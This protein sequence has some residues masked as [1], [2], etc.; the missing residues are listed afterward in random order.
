MER[1][2]SWA[3]LWE[4]LAS[5]S[6]TTGA[7]AW[8]LIAPLGAAW[9]AWLAW[10]CRWRPGLVALRFVAWFAVV[11]GLARVALEFALPQRPLAVVAAVDHSASIGTAGRQWQEQYVAELE[12]RLGP[13]DSLSVVAFAGRSEV[14]AWPGRPGPIHWDATELDEGSTDIAQALRR[15]ADLFPLEHERRLVLLSD[16]N[17][18]RSQALSEAPLL[19]ALG[20]QVFSAVPPLPEASGGRVRKVFAAPWL[21]AHSPASLHIGMDYRGRGESHQL[22]QLWFNGSLVQEQSLTLQ[23]GP[24][25]ISFDWQAPVAGAYHWRVRLR[26]ASGATGGHEAETEVAVGGPL[27]VLVVAPRPRSLLAQLWRERGWEVL[28]RSPER[29]RGERS[30]WDALH[31]VALE[32]VASADLPMAFWSALRRFAEE[33]GGVLVVG[34]HRTYNDTALSRTP[35]AEVLPVSPHPSPPPRR[36]RAPL[37]LVLVLDRSNSMA[38][39]VHRRLER[40]ESE[41]KLAYAKRAALNLIDQLRDTDWVGFVA[42]D[43][44]MYEVAPLRP[45]AENRA[46]LEANIPR[47]APGG[48]TDFYEALAHACRVLVAARA[49]VPHIILLTD[50]DTNRAAAEHDALIAELERAGVR[51]TTIRI[52]DDTVNLELLQAISARTGGNFYHVQDAT[53]LPELLLHDTAQTIQQA[54]RGSARYAVRVASPSSLLRNIPLEQLPDLGGYA[55]ARLKPEARLVL[56]VGS[57]E[58]S[59]PLL[60]VWNY[61]LGRVAAFTASLSNGA[62]TWASW[63]DLGKFF[64]QL[65][66]W[67]ARE[68]APADLWVRTGRDGPQVRLELLTDPTAEWGEARGRLSWGDQVADVLFARE[69][70]GRLVALL[71][72][73][74][75]GL[76][77]LTLWFRRSGREPEERR[78]AVY[79]AG[80]R[81]AVEETLPPNRSLLESLAQA[82]GGRAGATPAQVVARASGERSLEVSLQWLWL[83]LAIVAFVAEVAIRRLFLP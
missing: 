71:P 31:A 47:I 83:P 17:E 48:G 8:L 64:D 29:L 54:S 26:A 34:N 56:T 37:S 82:T 10:R 3:F 52:G 55:G 79:L 36:E 14:L 9:I 6:F 78:F 4:H 63:P 35:L 66:R 19:R 24:N 21:H 16:G 49:E 39:H 42:F 74:P 43:S 65:A 70:A 28:Q 45:L 23:P 53:R 57:A 61:G 41:S 33:G 68:R 12:R 59:D 58:R 15:A 80:P 69:E 5:A 2:L 77:E 72:T 22:V 67:A 13:D 46:W 30:D 18:T 44:Q 38:Y 7:P 20:I 32:D 76:A 25:L 75:A 81:Q 73:T 51:V 1:P 40:S 50:G 27:R 11:A 60:A 62:E